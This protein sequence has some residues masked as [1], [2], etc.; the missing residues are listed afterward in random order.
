MR[1]SRVTQLQTFKFFYNGFLTLILHSLLPFATSLIR[2]LPLRIL[3]IHSP[4]ARL[5]RCVITQSI[6]NSTLIDEAFAKNLIL[7]SN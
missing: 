2:F 6:A 5:R 3:Y 1:V 7:L 4:A